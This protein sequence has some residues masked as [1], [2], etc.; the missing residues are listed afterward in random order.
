MTGPELQSELLVRRRR[1][2]IIFISGERDQMF[3]RRL[4]ELGA[5]EYL[6]KPFSQGD[7]LAAVDAVFRAS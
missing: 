1:I 5:V 4:L 6:L 2:P 3:R 7:L